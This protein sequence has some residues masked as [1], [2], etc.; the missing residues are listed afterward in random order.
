M[1]EHVS[2]ELRSSEEVPRLV[3]AA[4]PAPRP[5]M[6]PVSSALVHDVHL[7]DFVKTFYKRRWSALTVF[8]VVF[9]SG[10]AVTFSTVPI[11][12]AKTQVLIEKENANVVNFKDPYEQNQQADDYYQTQY[13]LLQSR[14]LARRTLDAL[15]LWNHPQFGGSPAP[16]SGSARNLKAPVTWL[17]GFLK[18]TK[19]IPPKDPGETTV[20][21]Q[22]IDRFLGDLTIAPVRGS[23]LVD[24]KF[25]SPD[26]NTAATVVN[27]LARQYIEQNLEFKF[28]STKEAS[29]WLGQQLADQ[30]KKVE[31]SEQALQRY[32]E[33]TDAVA[34]D[35][36]QN[37]VVQKLADL[38]GAVTRAKTDRIQKEAQYNQIKALQ[39]DPATLD[40]F[41]AILSNSFIQQL[42][43]EL[44]ELQKQQAQMGEKLGARHPDM[45][46]IGSAIRNADAKLRGEIAKVVQAMGN[47]HR[48]ALAQEQGLVNALE[49]QKR[50]AL[51]LNRKGIDYNA[52]AR[53]AASNRQIFESLMQR[54]KETGISGELK[55]SN[56]RVVDVAEVPLAPASPNVRNNILMTFF[57]GIGL[58]IVV[59]FSFEYLDNRVKSPNDIKQH[60]GVPFL[61]MV[62]VI[63]K[64]FSTT[65]LMSNGI[66]VSFG[67]AFR[68]IRTNVLFSAAEPGCRSVMITS[69]GPGEGKTL[70]AT[71]LAVALAQAGQRVLLCDADMRKPRVHEVFGQ[72]LEPGL[73]NLMVGE[74][75]A[76]Q[77]VR[78]SSVPGL[79]LLP[80]GRQ[81]PNPSELLGSQRFKDFL[82]T[83]REHFEWVVLDTPPML[84]VT[85]A[86]VIAHVISDAVF[87]I[88]ADMTSRHAAQ[89]ALEQLDTAH[90]RV[91][92]AVLNRVDLDRNGYYYSQYYRREYSRYYHQQAG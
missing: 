16:P 15:A 66:P 36:K 79:W 23:R 40:T 20:Q 29:D 56:I 84:A 39:N 88:G 45:V 63:S 4:S 18:P 89:I 13:K 60:L 25:D 50:D 38:N 68:G 83:L 70:I 53:D 8:L 34:L 26:A 41:P 51:A 59:V 74:A 2:G 77:A 64:D 62:P 14:A 44:S 46:K 49:Q 72:A 54:T 42:K 28:L 69:T 76:S 48:A 87:V 6:M 67:E 58:A 10:V 65:P 27:G 82:A 73:S 17:A 1:A 78:Q 80:A 71:N 31:A 52:L 30:R 75:K 61:G 33:Q 90:P 37:I 92:G 21:S 55:T 43:T 5:S 81:P 3:M 47:E 35:D 7:L 85:D 24:I 57:A 32:R 19:P 11:Y 9:L 86:A 12:Q 91:I 22:T